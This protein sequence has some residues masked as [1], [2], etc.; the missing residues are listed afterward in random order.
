MKVLCMS[1]VALAVAQALLKARRVFEVRAELVVLLPTHDLELLQ[2]PRA[3]LN[4]ANIIPTTL[5][6]LCIRDSR[7]FVRTRTQSSFPMPL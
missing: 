4:T 5:L 7:D 2:T 3:Q 6:D 1:S